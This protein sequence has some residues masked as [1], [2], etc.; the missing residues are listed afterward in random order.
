MITEMQLQDGKVKWKN[1]KSPLLTWSSW[2]S[3]ENQ[4]NSSGIFSHGYRHC[5]FFKRSRKFA[6]KQIMK[7]EKFADLIRNQKS[8][9][10][11]E[12]ILA[13]SLDVLQPWG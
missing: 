7:P 2:E 12:E 3:M 4:L 1:S 5:R 6:K 10:K 8:Q 9:D 11:R 13:R